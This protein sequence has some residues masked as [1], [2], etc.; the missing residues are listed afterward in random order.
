MIWPPS[1]APL[2][3]D[4]QVSSG[5]RTVYQ[6]NPT[7]EKRGDLM[8]RHAVQR[9]RHRRLG[10]VFEAGTAAEQFARGFRDA[11]ERT[12][13]EVILFAP[14]PDRRAWYRLAAL[15]TPDTLDQL[16]AL[17]IPVTG[18]SAADRI[19]TALD[20]IEQTSGNVPLL[21]NGEWSERTDLRRLAR[22][23]VQF[24]QSFWIDEDAPEVRSFD[25]RYQA[26][27]GERPDSP[28][29]Y[30]GYDV[31]HFLLTRLGG[32]DDGRTLQE[33]FE[34]GGPYQGLS[35]TIDFTRSRV[36]DAI[37]ILEYTNGGVVRRY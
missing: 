28:Q 31:A 20:G 8:G 23:K 26:L 12:G 32:A 36:N 7:F 27:T 25:A 14:L 10:V 4:A 11:V 19:T 13:G 16:D 5:E 9:L 29:V 3:T 18:G 35:N 33:R 1:I 6:V 22:H 30:T 24:T 37:H 2:A 15:V 17:Y 34:A 21:G